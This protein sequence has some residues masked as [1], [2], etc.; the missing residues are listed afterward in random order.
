MAPR[1]NVDL[2]LRALDAGRFFAA[3]VSGADVSRGKPAPDIFLKAAAGLGI[4]MPVCEAVDALL[5]HGLNARS[6]VERLLARD[7]REE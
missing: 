6:A 3:T 2:C 1:E 4:E 7:P 5:H